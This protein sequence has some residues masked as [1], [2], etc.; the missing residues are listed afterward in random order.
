MIQ[1]VDYKIDKQILT[2]G[3]KVNSF[4]VRSS[5]AYDVN[6]TK[7]QL[8]Q[9]AYEQVKATIDYEKTL[10]EHA[11]T[12]DETGEVFIPEL[13]KVKVMTLI[14]NDN[15]IQFEENQ[16]EIIIELSSI[17]RDQYDESIDSTVTYTTTVGSIDNN[18]LTIPKVIEYTEVIVTANVGG[19]N[20]SK[21]IYL[22]PYEEPKPSIEQVRIQEL[23]QQLL[24]VQAY[25]VNKQYEELLQEGGL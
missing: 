17:V 10:S 15:H 14:V 6:K 22:Y 23:E 25:I 12:S 7:Q 16:E 9:Q 1:I 3:F 24:D 13:P 11:I 18:L 8:L 21:I 5:I 4:M 20:D 2:V 19:I